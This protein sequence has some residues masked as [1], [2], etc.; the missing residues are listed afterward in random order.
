M[1]TKTY[2]YPEQTPPIHSVVIADVQS[3]RDDA[4][5]CTLP[6]YGNMEVLLPTSEINVKRHKRV[7]DYVRVGQQIVVSVIRDDGARLDVSLKQVRANE[8]E[9]A[10]KQF[11]RDAR[12]NL[13]VRSAA[14]QDAAATAHLYQEYVWPLV[15]EAI[16]DEEVEDA[17]EFFEEVRAA[18]DE[19]GPEGKHGFPQELLDAIRERI[20]MPTKIAEKEIM[21]RQGAFHDGAA[22]TAAILD[23][24]AFTEGIKVYVVAPPKYR[25]VATDRTRAR[26]EARLE[27]AVADMPELA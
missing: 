8:T 17:Y 13:T 24:L 19:P 20:P 25:V 6:A 23:A 12:V 14:K 3:I 9:E 27:A 10:L 7:T 15:T 2:F 21:I 16:D 22:R 18:V 5:Y 1:A 4:V 26:A 11:H